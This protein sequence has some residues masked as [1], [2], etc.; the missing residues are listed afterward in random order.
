MKV[1][2]N[3]LPT[4]LHGEGNWHPLGPSTGQ[5]LSPTCPH[6]NVT[7][8]I[9]TV[10]QRNQSLG[11]QFKCDNHCAAEEILFLNLWNFN[12]FSIQ[13]M[14]HIQKHNDVP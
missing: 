3:A 5:V 8:F 11:F 6:L 2:Y 1:T 4:F 9:T 10:L 7:G 14:N 12:R 13:I